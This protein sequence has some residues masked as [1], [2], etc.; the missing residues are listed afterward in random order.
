MTDIEKDDNFNNL[1]RVLK[2]DPSV[3][4]NLGKNYSYLSYCLIPDKLTVKCH[5]KAI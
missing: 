1:K 5:R 2:L 3:R 4:Q